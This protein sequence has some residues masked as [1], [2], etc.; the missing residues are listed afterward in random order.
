[1]NLHST[2]EQKINIKWFLYLFIITSF[3]LN[4]ISEITYTNEY[5]DNQ[6]YPPVGNFTRI[7]FTHS[8]ITNNGPRTPPP[9][10]RQRKLSVDPP[11]IGKNS[12]SAH[13]Y[14]SLNN[15]FKSNI[16]FKRHFFFYQCI[17]DLYSKACRNP[18]NKIKFW[19]I[20]ALDIP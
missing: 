15:V 14:V 19:V 7:K 12:G 11:P 5:F 17:E 18:W 8:I 13:E 3:S 16:F 2:N 4:I 9:T 10:L 1:M 6:S 20:S